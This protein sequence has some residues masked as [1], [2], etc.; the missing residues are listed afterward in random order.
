MQ[1]RPW[2][3][4]HFYGSRVIVMFACDNSQ[5]F[6]A[7]SSVS[8]Q[9]Q[10]ESGA[11]WGFHRVHNSSGEGGQVKSGRLGPSVLN[12]QCAK[13]RNLQTIHFLKPEVSSMVRIILCR[14]A[15]IFN[16]L[17]FLT[18]K[19]AGF[20]VWLRNFCALK[21]PGFSQDS[22]FLAFKLFQNWGEVWNSFSLHLTGG[23]YAVL[24]GKAFLCCQWCSV[25]ASKF[26][27]FQ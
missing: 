10:P 17:L 4:N 16:Q 7:L 2:W 15:F 22:N 13:W 19:Q 11:G 14:C 24:M 5:L 23:K 1:Q 21:I 27:H 20:M 8:Q 3:K 9:S 18:M 25:K 12:A 6:S 26:L